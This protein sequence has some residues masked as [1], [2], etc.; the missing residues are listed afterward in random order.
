MLGEDTVQGRAVRWRGRTDQATT[1][2]WETFQT[3]D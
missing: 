2:R 3:V 1:E